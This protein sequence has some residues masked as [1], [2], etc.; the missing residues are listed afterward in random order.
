M[1]V[2]DQALELDRPDLSGTEID[3]DTADVRVLPLVR[4]VDDP[5]VDPLPPAA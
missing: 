2:T 4:L 3:G 1:D 5:D